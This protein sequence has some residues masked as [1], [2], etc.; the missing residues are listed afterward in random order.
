[1]FPRV[2]SA[3]E[4]FLPAYGLLVAIAFLAAV[5]L[6]GRLARRAGLDKEAVLNLAIYCALAGI[7]GAKLLMW[8]V[9]FRYYAGHPGEFF[10]F[11][12]LQAGG[13]FYGGLA[14]ALITAW[15]YTNRMGLPPLET[16]DAFA[17]G[18]ALG[19]AIGRLGCF[20]AG[21][22]WG[23]ECKRPWAVTF[24]NPLAITGVPL[25][26]PLHP[27]Q[28][29]EAAAELLIFAGLYRFFGRPHKPGA[30]IGLYVFLYGAVRFVVDFFRYH[31][32]GRPPGGLY[33]AQWIS[34][35]LI[36]CAVAGH[37][38]SH[39]ARTPAAGNA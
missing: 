39:R 2:F 9:D 17:P 13:I 3:G 4:F 12:T 25:N 18:L 34:L 6:T 32:P 30:V 29:Y 11:S 22:C 19:H 36:A 38:A 24:T 27:T 15:V 20:A 23:I 21:C 33:T 35:F 7:A 16:A 14:G 28:L 31:D 10:S 37:V 26:V 8:I 1:M 5:T